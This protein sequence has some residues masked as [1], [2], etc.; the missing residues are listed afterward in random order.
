MN[1]VKS[2]SSLKKAFTVVFSLIL[3]FIS[4]TRV[5]DKRRGTTWSEEIV[6]LIYN[7]GN[8][9]KV[10]NKLL[11]YRVEH[12]EVG[13]PIGHLRHLRKLKSPRL[14]ATHLPLPLIPK[15]L[16][17]GKCK[18]SVFPSSK[19]IDTKHVQKIVNCCLL[20]EQIKPGKRFG[21]C[22]QSEYAYAVTY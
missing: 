14:M 11:N 17:Q 2:C 22:W 21:V 19:I 6:S 16:R 13:R 1:F 15:R 12:L 4:V 3:F 20:R 18:V 9:N 8:P 5:A 7:D 10:K